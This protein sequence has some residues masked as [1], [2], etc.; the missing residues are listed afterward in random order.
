M[1]IMRAVG[2]AAAAAAATVAVAG[3]GGGNGSP[4]SSATP[5]T[6]ATSSPAPSTSS[7]GAVTTGTR[8]SKERAGKI[9]TDKYGGEVINVEADT[10]D[11]EPVW[12]V[13]VKNSHEG[14][15]EVDVTQ[16]GGEIVDFE[17]D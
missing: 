8:I 9:V 16:S 12:E 14:R 4:D 15:I 10:H 3:C 11:G 1:S 5:S 13:E 6:T 2:V 17:H 7:T